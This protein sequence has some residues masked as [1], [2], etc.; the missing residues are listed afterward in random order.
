MEIAVMRNLP[1]KNS[2]LCNQRRAIVKHH[3]LSCHSCAVTS[4]LT[5]NGR[6]LDGNAGTKISAEGNDVLVKRLMRTGVEPKIM[7]RTEVV[8]VVV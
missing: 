8:Y 7:L 6:E 2:L 1:G 4:M 5:V 3:K